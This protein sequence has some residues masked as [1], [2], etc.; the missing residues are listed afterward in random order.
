[1]ALS[2]AKKSAKKIFEEKNCVILAVFSPFFGPKILFRFRPF[3]SEVR[4]ELLMYFSGKVSKSRLN[5]K[6]D[7]VKNIYIFKNL[8]FTTLFL[9]K[10]LF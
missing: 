2:P 7:V 8:L 3:G 4:Y 1:M 9:C 10:R 6:C 5:L